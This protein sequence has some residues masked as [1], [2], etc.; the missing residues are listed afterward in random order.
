MSAM[1]IPIEDAVEEEVE[2]AEGFDFAARV[3]ELRCHSTDS[4][5]RM[6]KDARTEQQRWHL[7][8]LAALRV[9]DD[10]DALGPLK[11]ATVSSRTATENLVAARAFEQ[12]P[13][14]AEA[15][16]DGAVSWDQARSLV[17]LATPETDAEW[18]RR[19]PNLQPSD[20]ERKVRQARTVTSD[21]V[22]RRRE[23]R[24]LVTWR[25]DRNGMAAGKFLLPDIDGVLV[26]KVLEHMAEQRRPAK[27][28][29]W[30]SLAHRKA[31]A[32]VGLCRDY[33][34]VERSGRFRMEIVNIAD[35]NATSYGA[36]VAGIPLAQEQIVAL[37]PSAKV[38]D[39]VVDENGLAT[40]VKTP[41][42]ALPK[43]VERHVRRRDLHCRLPGCTDPVHDIHHMNP[44]RDFGD[45]TDPRELAG[46]CKNDH[47]MLV[48][49]GPYWLIGDAEE[50]D[51]LRLVHR[52]ELSRDGQARD[53]P[54]P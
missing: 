48:P 33:A 19:G 51:G 18:A 31:D 11:D 35:P 50:P 52:D 37:I 3:N 6:V 53:G 15:T 20:I 29:P 5:R 21:D 40:T 14:L 38:R 45:T 28:M 24:M 4:L 7:E 54:S 44:V 41:R 10:R 39:C 27:G 25:D 2:P 8:E 47:R 9:L 32:L 42:R 16:Y 1:P 30:D 36:E 43:D 22:A 23:A 13:R 12:L 46:V 17:Q 26:E 34:D 49:N